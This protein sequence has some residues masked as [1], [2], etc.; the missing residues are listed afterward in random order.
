MDYQHA[1]H[2]QQGMRGQAVLD[3]V[4]LLA[5]CGKAIGKCPQLRLS[6]P[7]YLVQNLEADTRDDLEGYIACASMP[8]RLN[9]GKE[10]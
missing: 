4:K 10:Q 2:G 9:R 8:C 5:V 7:S 1:R 6:I 3:E